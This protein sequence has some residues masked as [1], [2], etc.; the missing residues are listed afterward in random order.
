M[1]ISGGESGIWLRGGSVFYGDEVTVRDND[2]ATRVGPGASAF[3]SNCSILDNPNSGVEASAG[4]TVLVRSCEI[5][6]NGQGLFAAQSGTIMGIDLYVTDNWQGV[7]GYL[8]GEISVWSSTIE[9]NLRGVSGQLN[10]SIKIGAGTRVAD[11]DQFGVEMELGSVF[12]ASDD[13]TI[14]GNGGPGIVAR[15]ASTISLGFPNPCIVRDNDGDGILLLDQS[16]GDVGD[17]SQVVDNG[18]W[19][20]NCAGPSTITG[21]QLPGGTSADLSG[22]TA[23]GTNCP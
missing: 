23:G 20:I 10:S 8:G 9:Q 4:G 2:S 16:N 18:G 12:V 13:S 5:R 17:D 3:L 7:G 21:V 1:T 19:G 14:E 22:N 15:G 11:N 6:G